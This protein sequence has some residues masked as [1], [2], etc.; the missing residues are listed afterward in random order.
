M[1]DEVAQYCNNCSAVVSSG[2]HFCNACGHEVG[3][4]FAPQ[5]PLARHGYCATCHGNG[6]RLPASIVYCPTCRWLR[7]LGPGY[8]VDLD[9]FM[10]RFDAEGMRILNSTGPIASAAHG[11]AQR[12]GRPVFEA[13]ANGI[14]LSERQMPDIFELAIHA[15]RLL[16]LMHLPEIYISGEQMWDI[17]SLGGHEGSFVAI[18][19]VLI[20]MRKEDLLFLLAR[21][22][23]HIRA[24]HV[25]WKTAMQFLTGAKQRQATIMGEGVLQFLNPLKIMESAVEA[26]LMS[27]SRHSEITADRAALLVTGDLA[28]ARRAL[29]QWAMKS[30]PVYA[31]VNEEVWLEQEALSDDPNLKLSEWTMSATPYLAPRLKVLTEFA[32][33]GGFQVSRE[34]IEA[35]VKRAGLGQGVTTLSEPTAETERIIC[36]AC[37]KPLRVAK[38][39]FESGKT[40]NVRC[41]QNRCRKILK[42]KPKEPRTSS[43]SNLLARKVRLTCVTC[44]QTMFVDRDD[45]SG[46]R[47][48]LVRCPE[49][50]CGALLNVKPKSSIPP[51]DQIS[52]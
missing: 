52:D 18:G 37:H 11:I 38:S 39:T 36:T 31:K 49:K 12:F 16:S 27:W 13:A 14:R 26:P 2:S 41:P 21:E 34:N 8:M 4:P 20:N 33:E 1:S 17:Y 15:A 22:M 3:A 51:P 19:S 10:W 25:Y 5:S 6:V 42:I 28:C 48:T 35:F 43:S 24:G 23:G 9:A 50:G 44:H 32:A 30:F 29:T 7:P 45:L 47:P 40:V 46:D